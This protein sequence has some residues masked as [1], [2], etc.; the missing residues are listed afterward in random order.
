MTTTK[1]YWRNQA[2]GPGLRF[3]RRQRITRTTS[4]ATQKSRAKFDADEAREAIARLN[5]S[6]LTG[7]AYVQ[8][9]DKILG[10]FC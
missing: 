2:Y 9:L 3:R 1:T 10:L 5:A 4:A 7:N 6:G 8:R